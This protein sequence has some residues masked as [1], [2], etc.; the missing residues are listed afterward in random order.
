M[1]KGKNMSKN[2]IKKMEKNRF[3]KNIK[4]IWRMIMKTMEIKVK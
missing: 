4:M 3:I 2:K 1:G